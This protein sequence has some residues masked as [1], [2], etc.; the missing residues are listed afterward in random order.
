MH[1]TL[2]DEKVNDENNKTTTTKKE[3]AKDWMAD[4]LCAHT[5]SIVICAEENFDWMMRRK[6]IQSKA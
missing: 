4:W 1:F 2:V 6:Q 5:Q 3:N